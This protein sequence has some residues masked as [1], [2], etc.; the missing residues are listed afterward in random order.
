MVVCDYEIYAK[1]F[2]PLC[3]RNISN[4][5]INGNNKPN[6]ISGKL[7][8]GFHIKTVAFVMPMWNIVSKILETDCLKKIMKYHPSRYPI[9]VIITING[10]FFVFTYS[11]KKARHSSA[12]VF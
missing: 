2:T 1:I 3:R 7:I 12:H 5:A 4:T 6:I 9:S 8:Y 10:N 11:K